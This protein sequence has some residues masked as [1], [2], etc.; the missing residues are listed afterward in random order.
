M[1]GANTARSSKLP[2]TSTS[3]PTSPPLADQPSRPAPVEV[4]LP[5]PEAAAKQ[6]IV[7]F[8]AH[9]LRPH[10][11]RTVAPHAPYQGSIP[12]VFAVGQGS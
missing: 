2:G 10:P 6:P 3:G 7:A 11:R 1:S 9:C 5:E 12:V 4:E 8:V